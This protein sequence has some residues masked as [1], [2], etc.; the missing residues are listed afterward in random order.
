MLVSTELAFSY[1]IWSIKNV[2]KVIYFVTI[3]L[4]WANSL[5]FYKEFLPFLESSKTLSHL[6]S[7]K[8]NG[9]QSFKIKIICFFSLFN[10]RL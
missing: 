3:L 2:W 6:D 4:F 10:V 1:F 7:K 8:K 5:D 9:I